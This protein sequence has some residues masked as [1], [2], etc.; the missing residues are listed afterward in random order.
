MKPLEKREPTI[1]YSGMIPGEEPPYRPLLTERIDIEQGRQELG[2][3]SAGLVNVEDALEELGGYHREPK[4]KVALSYQDQCIVDWDEEDL[5]NP[6]A[7]SWEGD[8]YSRGGCSP[9][10]IAWSGK[11]GECVSSASQIPSGGH[12]V[13]RTHVLYVDGPIRDL[14]TQEGT[15]AR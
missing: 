2:Q 9:H 5:K 1:T 12:N 7:Y 13:Y 14:I 6:S 15:R 4:L 11:T 8:N 10:L 3:V